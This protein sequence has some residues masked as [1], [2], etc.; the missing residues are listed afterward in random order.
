[1]TNTVA[2]P[3]QKGR[4]QREANIRANLKR[5]ENRLLMVAF[6]L[7]VVGGPASIFLKMQDGLADT[8]GTILLAAWAIPC[9]VCLFVVARSRPN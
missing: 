5:L 7:V 2:H 8:I 4:A 6:A 3:E 1:M 9:H